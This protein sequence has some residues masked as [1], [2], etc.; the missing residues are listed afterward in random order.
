MQTAALER[1]VFEAFLAQVKIL[2]QQ[3]NI[4][5]PRGFISYAWGSDK[6][7]NQQLQGWL[8]Q[9]KKDF[10][11]LDIDVFLDLEEMNGNM[12]ECMRRIEKKDFILLIGNPRFKERAEQDVLYILPRLEARPLLPT[13]GNAV[14]LIEGEDWIYFM[15]NGE[16][17]GEDK[18][19]NQRI[20]CKGVEWVQE[21]GYKRA[22]TS[23]LV[24]SILEDTIA[25][26]STR[27]ITNVAF[28][29]GLALDKVKN[30]AQALL[31]LLYQGEVNSAFPKDVAQNLIRDFRGIEQYF[32]NFAS[33]SPMGLI[34]AVCPALQRDADYQK[35]ASGFLEW[36]FAIWQAEAEERSEQAQ[37]AFRDLELYIPARGDLSADCPSPQPMETHIQD[38]LKTQS[39]DVLLLLGGSGSGKSMFGQ[40]FVH[41]AW[42][43]G[44]VPLWISLPALHNPREHAIEEGLAS[45]GIPECHWGLF[46]QKRL[47][48]ILDAYDEV[49]N[50]G[51]LYDSN[52]LEIW[53]KNSKVIITCRPE[54]LRAKS[55][56]TLFKP[57]NGGLWERHMAP[58]S[59]REREAYLQKYVVVR[60]P[61]WDLEHYQIEINRLPIL[62]ELSQTPFLLRILAEVL[63]DIIERQPAQN[64]HLTRRALYEAFV[65]QWFQKHLVRWEEQQKLSLLDEDLDLDP[66]AQDEW[67]DQR[68][69]VLRD[70]AESLA[71]QMHLA[72]I[73]AVSLTDPYPWIKKYF[74]TK[75]R[76]RL[77]QSACPLKKEGNNSYKFIHKSVSE[78]LVTLRIVR[79]QNQNVISFTNLI[80]RELLTPAMIGFLADAVI[81]K[82]DL[83]EQLW[84]IIQYSK[85]SAQVAIAAANAIS[86]LNRAQ[87][88]FSG[89]DFRGIRIPGADLRGAILDN[90]DCRGADFSNVILQGAWL[91]GANFSETIMNG[92]QF[93]AL[94]SLRFNSFSQGCSCSKNNHWLAIAAN[95]CVYLYDGV[96]REARG[97]LEGNDYIANIAFSPDEKLL[98]SGNSDGTINVWSVEE[99][100]LLDASSTG[101]NNRSVY[102]VAFSHDGKLLASGN[103]D[104]TINVWN[105][106]ETGLVV[107]GVLRGH[108]SSVNSIAFS[109]SK[110]LLVSCSGDNFFRR[111]PEDGSHIKKI[112]GSGDNTIRLWN[113]NTLS[114]DGDPLRGH[115]SSINSIA[116]SSDGR[117][118]A[119]GS[120]DDFF[121]K[122][123]GDDTGI[124]LW[125]LE[126][127]Q[128]VKRLIGHTYD[129]K[130]VI[131]NPENNQQLASGAHDCS[132]RL[133]DLSTGANHRVLTAHTGPVIDLAFVKHGQQLVSV[134]PNDPV[135][136]W[137]L[138]NVGYKQKLSGHSD[139]VTSVA[140]S[141]NNPELLASGSLDH[142]VRL[143]DAKT[144]F[145]KAELRG[146]E[147][148]VSS[149]KFSCNGQWIASGSE[150][151]T[152]RLWNVETNTFERILGSHRQRHQTEERK[153][154]IRSVAFSPDG[155]LLASGGYDETIRLWNISGGIPRV[156]EQAHQGRMTSL[157]FSPNG[158]LLASGGADKAIKLWN[159]ST[160]RVAQPFLQSHR[161]EVTSLAFSPNGTLLASGGGD[162][163]DKNQMDCDIRIWNVFTGQIL[164]ILPGHDGDI[165]SLAFNSNGEFLASSSYDRTIRFW[166]VSAGTEVK[167]LALFSWACALVW[168]PTLSARE[169]EHLV[170]GHRDGSVLYWQVKESE[171]NS[172]QTQLLWRMVSRES[173][174]TAQGAFLSGAQLSEDNRQLLIESGATAQEFR[175][176]SH[177]GIENTDMH[178]A[179]SILYLNDQTSDHVNQRADHSRTMLV[180]YQ[181]SPQRGSRVPVLG[182]AARREHE[183]DSRDRCAIL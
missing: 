31:P 11:Q 160:L 180:Q 139:Y 46:K 27:N 123:S 94:P 159:P 33:V 182:T 10:K 119:S 19:L 179:E 154:W 44:F 95:N 135:R 74:D 63:P 62:K 40:Y 47:L 53:G 86:I 57:R 145:C 113:V 24:N 158:T 166:S 173:I 3:K 115:T 178:P 111:S 84:S 15:E 112:P 128:C 153:G 92:T 121:T 181:A 2:M 125:N 21:P 155:N 73:D 90:T 1:Q 43:E 98:A 82:P 67:N 18:R 54:Y 36:N 64:L 76:S 150:D 175:A 28:E 41:Q 13:R 42:P 163:R 174:L 88:S 120:G 149:V 8:T 51:N 162:Y 169:P 130:K 133:W 34:Q 172:L 78:Y 142:T 126:T 108:N 66:E 132:V 96:T 7:A 102:C 177:H 12:R 144:G 81:E 87:I 60:N 176:E 56:A 30:S 156:I 55:Y 164:K 79:E 58:F 131:F 71:H 151:T 116:F 59:E 101:D 23:Q 170:S 50:L 104:G 32:N 5:P 25:Q 65:D 168:K 165:T 35:L 127:R 183:P 77:L 20:D 49:K 117:F 106:Q 100:V 70:Y 48:I 148:V 143:W 141:V 89:K 109:P 38:F 167:V 16:W 37:R 9:L 107:K 52:H 85:D 29:F 75:A 91:N 137:D 110:E 103:S 140:F 138:L 171:Q 26:V 4:H 80:N 152:V 69:S 147:G 146:H 68:L 122:I 161:Q 22:K 134:A 157:A 114:Q 97:I 93:F 136:V 99:R 118:L 61:R 6:T 17:L 124:R 45:Y 83:Q 105:V 39:A 14:V 129:V 72:G